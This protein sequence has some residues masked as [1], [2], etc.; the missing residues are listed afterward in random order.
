MSEVTDGELV[1]QVRRGNREAA[2]RLAERYLPACHAVALSV[3]RDMDAAEDV[4]Q[5]AFVQAM[6]KIDD[7]RDPARFGRWL[8]VIVRNRSRNYLRD[9]KASSKAT[10]EEHEP[11]SPLPLPDRSAERAELRERLLA[12]METLSEERRTILLLHDLEGWTHREIAEQ[13]GLPDG[14]IRS[15]LHHARKHLRPHLQG[16]MDR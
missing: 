1:G 13:L 5:D 14:T 8:L 12:A 7:C 9:S 4:C 3:L 10:I 15:H 16:L 2:G 6:E 11:G